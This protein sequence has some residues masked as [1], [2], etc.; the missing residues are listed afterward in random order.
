MGLPLAHRKAPHNCVN[1][2][3]FSPGMSDVGSPQA[4][5]REDAYHFV[6]EANEGG[7]A[8]I[9]EVAEVE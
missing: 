1:K 3:V 7:G 6:F 8:T 2:V 4:I 9:V 5:A